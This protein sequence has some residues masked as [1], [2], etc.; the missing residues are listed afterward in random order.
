[1]STDNWQDAPGLRDAALE[2]FESGPGRIYS[3]GYEAGIKWADEQRRAAGW[4]TPDEAERLKAANYAR[5]RRLEEMLAEMRVALADATMVTKIT[6][7]Q[8]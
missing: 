7:T 4:L 8:P 5:V 6:E 2:G 3:V 1:M